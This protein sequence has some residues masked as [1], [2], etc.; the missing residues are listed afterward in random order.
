M[1]NYAACHVAC[2]EAIRKIA[3]LQFVPCTNLTDLLM[4]ITSVAVVVH[5][6]LK[7]NMFCL[8]LLK[9]DSAGHVIKSHH[10]QI[11]RL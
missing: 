2:F 1:Q 4:D 5:Y 3:D 7:L 8:H 10:H 6:V 9:D 11:H